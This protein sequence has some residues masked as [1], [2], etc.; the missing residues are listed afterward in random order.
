MKYGANRQTVTMMMAGMAV[1]A[2]VSQSMRPKPKGCSI[3]L[4]TP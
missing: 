3:W 2:L 1:D 4:T